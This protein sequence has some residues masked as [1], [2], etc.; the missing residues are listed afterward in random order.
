METEET[1]PIRSPA[2]AVA[3]PATFSWSPPVRARPS[4]ADTTMTPDA[5]ATEG[6]YR[7]AA[8]WAWTDP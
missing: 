2:S 6:K 4:A 3:R 7:T 8:V 5:P 1:E